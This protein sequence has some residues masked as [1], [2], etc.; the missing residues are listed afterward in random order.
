MEYIDELHKQ[1]WWSSEA[2]ANIK[3]ELEEIGGEAYRGCWLDSYLGGGTK[4]YPRLWWFSDIKI[5]KK[6]YRLLA[7]DEV[8]QALKAIA[9]WAELDWVEG[10]LRRISAEMMKLEGDGEGCK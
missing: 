9:L 4:R 2:I 8:G 6:H 5:H 10:E 1:V 3:A 7:D